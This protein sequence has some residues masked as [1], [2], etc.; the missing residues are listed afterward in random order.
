MN[1]NSDN[2]SQSENNNTDVQKFIVYSEVCD[3]VNFND[4]KIEEETKSDNNEIDIDDPMENLNK[5]L[6]HIEHQNNKK[7]YIKLFRITVALGITGFGILG[8]YCYNKYSSNK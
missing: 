8:W 6:D 2:I 3:F 7:K 5:T 1:N 4:N